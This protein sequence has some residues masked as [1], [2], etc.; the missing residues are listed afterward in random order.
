VV[1]VA[2]ADDA[3]ADAQADAQQEEATN[4]VAQLQVEPV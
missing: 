4:A 1:I 3:V 2:D